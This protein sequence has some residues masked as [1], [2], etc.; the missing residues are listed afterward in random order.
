MKPGATTADP[1]VPYTEMSTPG[2]PNGCD[3]CRG[4]REQLQKHEQKLADYVNDPLHS[5]LL[6]RGYLW[7]DIEF[8]NGANAESII[9]GRIRNLKEQVGNFRRQ[10][11]E[12][13]MK[14]FGA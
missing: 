4:L 1:A 9:Q 5:D 2:D 7:F 11:E 13:M 14:H 10:Y 12:C 8:R 6:S 3:P